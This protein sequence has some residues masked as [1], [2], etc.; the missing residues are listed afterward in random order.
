MTILSLKI[1]G[2]TDYLNVEIKTKIYVNILLN[3]HIIWKKF[4]IVHCFQ[5]NLFTL[6]R[7]GI[8]LIRKKNGN[9]F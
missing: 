9:L 4:M 7:I 5:A 1:Y 8:V 3:K 2:Y 6:A